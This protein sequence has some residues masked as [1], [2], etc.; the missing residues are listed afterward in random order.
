MTVL[1]RDAPHDL[2]IGIRAFWPEAE[3]EHA[4]NIAYLESKWNRLAVLNTTT[5]QTPCGAP[6]TP[7]N[8][9][10]V[11][12]EFSIGYFQVN[13]CNFPEWDPVTLFDAFQNCGTAHML[14][15]DAGNSW[16]PWYFSAKSL[17]LLP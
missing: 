12:A 13:S 5:P 14:W 7:I 10:A 6:L 16:S 1:L 11:V 3:W 15:A 8:G 17:G 4:A 2:R 9:V